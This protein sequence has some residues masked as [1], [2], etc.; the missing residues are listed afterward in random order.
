VSG[1]P[2]FR[3]LDVCFDIDAPAREGELFASLFGDLAVDDP[4]AVALELHR[5]RRHR[6]RVRFAGSVRVAGTT[7]GGALAETLIAVN[8]M[9]GRTVDGVAVLHAGGAVIGGGAVAFAGVSGAGKSTLTAAAVRRGHPYLCDEVCAVADGAAGFAVRPYHRPIGLRPGG[10]AA[11]D[12]A[13]PEL[14]GEPF[15]DVYP[16]RVSSHGALAGTE[17]LRLVCLVERRDGPVAIEPVRPAEALVRLSGLTIGAE[18]RERDMFHRLDEL[19]RAVPVVRLAF[20]DV[21]SAVDAVEAWR[22]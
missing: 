21:W 7:L 4:A 3:A 6:W 15:T 16:W 14:R 18:G 8:E 10:A 22:P 13:I 17:P 19:V 11:I 1:R 20:E 12:V 2:V 9:A 5:E